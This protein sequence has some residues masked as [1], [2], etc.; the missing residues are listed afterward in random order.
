[1]RY[2][3]RQVLRA[4]FGSLAAVLLLLP[5]AGPEIAQ[6]GA[7][8]F[9]LGMLLAAWSP[10]FRA[11][12]QAAI[13]VLAHRQGIENLSPDARRF[14]AQVRRAILS[15]ET[16]AAYDPAHD[17]SLKS[18]GAALAGLLLL[19]LTVGSGALMAAAFLL[20]FAEIRRPR[21]QEGI[22]IARAIPA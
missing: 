19:F 5:L 1:M 14:V 12:H 9:S 16:V 22:R 7:L 10:E 15:P 2:I 11:G 20:L 21:I 17:R 6:L 8:S 18:L 3:D 13:L 4:G